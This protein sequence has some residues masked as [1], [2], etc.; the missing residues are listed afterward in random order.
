MGKLLLDEL[1]TGELLPELCKRLLAV[2]N[3]SPENTDHLWQPDTA[4]DRVVNPIMDFKIMRYMPLMTA[5]SLL[6]LAG[7]DSGSSSSGDI[8]DVD[9]TEI[10]TLPA[11][12]EG[13]TSGTADLLLARFSGATFVAVGADQP[14]VD[15]PSGIGS[16]SFTNDTVTVTRSEIV[17]TGSF[18][19]SQSSV[20]E[21]GS[22]VEDFSDELIATFPDRDVPFSSDAGNLIW[23][24]I[25][26]RRADGSQFSS[27]E[28][29]VEY[30]DGSVFTSTEQFDITGG[31][32][33]GQPL[34]SWVIRFDGD[35][36][37]WAERG[38]VVIVG[39]VSV[40]DDSTFKV[41]FVNR[42]ITVVALNR[43]N[44]VIDA[45]VYEKDRTIQ[46][47][48]QETLVEF[49][50]GTSFRSTSLQSLGETS[51]GVTG[52]GYWFVDFSGDTYNWSFLDIEEAGT[53]SFVDN[54]RFS[55]ELS[56]RKLIVEVE[57]DEFV[58]VDVRYRKVVGE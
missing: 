33:E 14:N 24:S 6:V 10:D 38:G 7:C 53:I 8:V 43:N 47:D 15:S 22:Y 11:E 37:F 52:V 34:T 57:G 13:E 56:D 50:D 9:S 42:E 19:Q 29:L 49:L 46:F 17:L 48:S 51:P 44:L 25:S 30:L 5:I 40:I 45:V 4:I 23:D 28:S 20:T 55:A 58:W 18:V 41:E 16:V 26:Y 36:A 31:Q 54:N 39:T 1:L 32:S 2:S 3:P 21:V 12:N 27:Q 35:Q